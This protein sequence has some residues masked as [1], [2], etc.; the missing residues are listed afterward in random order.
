[1]TVLLETISPA[2]AV[3]AARRRSLFLNLLQVAG[4]LLIVG[5]HT[6]V[7]GTQFAQVALELFFV[8]AGLNMARYVDRYTTVTSLL[9]SRVR[10]L[11]PE[12]G[13]VWCIAL[14]AFAVS[15]RGTGIE[16]FLITTPL[17]LQNF[18]EPYL[19]MIPGVNWVFLDALW[20]AAAL[21]QLQVLLYVVRGVFTRYRP[22]FLVGAIAGVGI[23]FAALVAAFHGGVTRNLE[24][25]SSDAIYRMAITHV[26]PFAFG[27]MLG[28]GLL[29]R[30]GRWFPLLAG[31]TAILA[32]GNYILAG[33]EI[34]ISSC[35]FPVGM[36][37]NFQYLWGYPLVAL[38]L[39]SF[40]APDGMIAAAV[41][42]VGIGR[43]WEFVLDRLAR[44]TYGVYIF[45]GLIL[46]GVQ[47]ELWSRGIERTGS[48]KLVLFAVVAC[49]AF[50]A[51]WAFQRGW[52]WA[53]CRVC[54]EYPN[55]IAAKPG[56]L[57]ARCLACGYLG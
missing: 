30:F 56:Q 4:V 39:A 19:Q 15:L 24:Y 26:S 12:I 31:I 55:M 38:L 34:G 1:M 36:P 33:P 49:S 22:L 54:D 42:R 21:V 53:R 45:H 7:R 48:V 10:R 2:P 28:R 25:A 11:A 35:G 16:I 5:A 37:F 23:L 57:P 46:A 18:A 41:E 6:G 44:L 20:F 32:I 47:Y 51:A 40:C 43:R 9:W 50:T 52:R 27:F 3:C 8:I 14:A 29:P 13:V 17:F